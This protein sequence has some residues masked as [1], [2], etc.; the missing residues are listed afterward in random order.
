L[1]GP[2]HCG[3]SIFIKMLMGVLPVALHREQGPIWVD[4]KMVTVRRVRD[5]LDAGLVAVF[6]DDDLLPTMTVEEQLLLRHA[7]PRIKHV[8]A[9][10]EGVFGKPVR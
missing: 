10:C 4:G 3:K 6:Q 8:G 5:A 1:E 7:A 2:N 9:H